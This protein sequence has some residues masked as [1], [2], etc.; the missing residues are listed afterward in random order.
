[1]CNF[2]VD[3]VIMLYPDTFTATNKGSFAIEKNY[4]DLETKC[5]VTITG[6]EL[7]S[8]LD[9]R[10]FVLLVIALKWFKL[11]IFGCMGNVDML[12][13]TN[14]YHLLFLS[15]CRPK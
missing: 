11:I 12:A 1:L 10:Y 3:L 13:S 9:S 6:V 15:N 4:Q 5:W 14:M 8:R 2:L 7:A